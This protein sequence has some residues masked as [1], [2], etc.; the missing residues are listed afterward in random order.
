MLTC[1]SAS[2]DEISVTS[3]HCKVQGMRHHQVQQKYPWILDTEAE[4][5]TAVVAPAAAR[6]STF[7]IIKTL[8][9]LGCG[10]LASIRKSANESFSDDFIF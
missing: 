7:K 6:F 5:Y 9:P 3:E 2:Q 4:L 1:D 10:L 8:R